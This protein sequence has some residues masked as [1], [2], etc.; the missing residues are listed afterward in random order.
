MIFNDLTDDAEDYVRE[1][2]QS[3]IMSADFC[4]L[5]AWARGWR[6]GLTIEDALRFTSTFTM[7]KL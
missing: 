1:E 2:L 6:K 5:H 3:T 7:K 4:Q